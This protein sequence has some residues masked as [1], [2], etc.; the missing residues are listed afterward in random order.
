[1][2]VARLGAL[3]GFLT[4]AFVTSACGPAMSDSADAAGDDQDE[5]WGESTSLGKAD[6]AGMTAAHK[7][8]LAKFAAP[9]LTEDEQKDVLDRYAD[10]D[11]NGVV[12]ADLLERALVYYDFNRDL[13]DNDRYLTVIDFAQHSSKKRLYIVDMQDGSLERHVVAHGS[14]S[15]PN[16]DGVPT[17]FSNVAN[18]HKSSLGFYLTAETYSGKWGLSL[19]LD[20]LSKSN[21]EARDRAIVMH[22]ASYVESGKSKQGRS[23]GCPAIPLSERDDVIPMLKGGSLMYAERSGE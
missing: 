14:G 17:E 7:E 15:D 21:S 16:N 11:P 9:D 6:G 2:S 20:G 12:P 4:I 19:R 3:F 10:I 13:L 1:M 18:S 5:S 8:L 22:G 23:W